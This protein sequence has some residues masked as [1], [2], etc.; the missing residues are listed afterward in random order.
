MWEPFTIAFSKQMRIMRSCIDASSHKLVYLVYQH[1]S[2]A[3]F[4]PHCTTSVSCACAAIAH[5]Q[6]V[7]RRSIHHCFEH[8]C[9]NTLSNFENFLLTMEWFIHLYVWSN[10]AD[11]AVVERV[12]AQ[13]HVPSCNKKLRIYLIGTRL[14][15]I[16]DREADIAQ[17]LALTRQKSRTE[18]KQ[19]KHKMFGIAKQTPTT[20]SRQFLCWWA[21]EKLVCN[22]YVCVTV[23]VLTWRQQKY[24]HIT[25][26]SAYAHMQHTTRRS[27]CTLVNVS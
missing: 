22:V 25:K 27:L 9:L 8:L 20:S 3:N 12:C 26:K 21:N 23:R 13:T 16:M 7:L 18:Q 17:L 2:V 24:M 1:R 15:A 11:V 10:V 6:N 14:H 19:T 5:C 4:L